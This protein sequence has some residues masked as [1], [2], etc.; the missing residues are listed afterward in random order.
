MGFVQWRQG[1]DEKEL[2]KNCS[3]ASDTPIDLNQV[4]SVAHTIRFRRSEEILSS[5][6]CCIVEANGDTRTLCETWALLIRFTFIDHF[7]FFRT[8]EPNVYYGPSR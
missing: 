2:K 7:F 5:S 6:L 8:E 3:F 4:V 1:S